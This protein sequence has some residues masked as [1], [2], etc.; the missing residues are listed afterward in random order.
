MSERRCHDALLDA[1][2]AWLESQ[3][4]ETD[5]A[6][7]AM[8]EMVAGIIASEAGSLEHLLE[9]VAMAQKQL[10]MTAVLAYQRAQN[11]D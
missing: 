1:L 8:T 3:N 6:G 9:G 10:M 11:D 2:T 5:Q 7:A 4:L